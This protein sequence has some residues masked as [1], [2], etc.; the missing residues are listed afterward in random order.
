MCKNI[1]VEKLVVYYTFSRRESTI[2][3]CEN[4]DVEKL[5]ISY[6]FSRRESTKQMCETPSLRN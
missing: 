4:I 1:E 2:Q 3:I 5:G 6:T